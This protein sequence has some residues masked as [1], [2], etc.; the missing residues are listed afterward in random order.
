MMKLS[1]FDFPFDPALVALQP[2]HPRDRARLLVLGRTAERLR[3]VPSRI[4]LNY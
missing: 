1:D 4:C 2:V 3:I